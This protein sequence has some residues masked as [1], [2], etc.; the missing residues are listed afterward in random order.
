MKNNRLLLVCEYEPCA[1]WIADLQT[2]SQ[3]PRVLREFL[4]RSDPDG[5]GH[6]DREAVENFANVF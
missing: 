5:G 6:A 2:R 3:D 1:L 4:K